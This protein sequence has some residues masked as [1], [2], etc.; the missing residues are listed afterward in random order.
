MAELPSSWSW[1]R[2]TRLTKRQLK[3]LIKKQQRSYQRGDQ[4]EKLSSSFHTQEREQA[5]EDLA[6]ELENI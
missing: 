1:W 4:I 2:W 5:E 6:Q 3:E